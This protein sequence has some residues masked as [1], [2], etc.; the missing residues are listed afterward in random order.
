MFKVIH[1]HLKF[2]YFSIVLTYFSP[3]RNACRI[4]LISRLQFRNAR[5]V[6]CVRTGHRQRDAIMT[7]NARCATRPNCTSLRSHYARHSI[8]AARSFEQPSPPQSAMWR[9]LSLLV[10]IYIVVFFICARRATRCHSNL[11]EFHASTICYIYIDLWR[12]LS[13][14]VKVHKYVRLVYGVNTHV[15]CVYGIV[16]E[17]YI[18]SLSELC[19][20]FK[21]GIC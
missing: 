21:M 15:V 8:V 6:Q 12:V 20:F 2:E 3:A 9:K 17:Q 14:L 1:I 10:Q 5:D 13:K 7:L 16:W 4:V 18:V 11:M 19:G